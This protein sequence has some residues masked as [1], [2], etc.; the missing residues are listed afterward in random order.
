MLKRI[1]I[2]LLHKSYLSQVVN[3]G[4]FVHGRA[5]CPP[6]AV[7]GSPTPPMASHRNHG[8]APASAGSLGSWL[9]GS[10]GNQDPHGIMRINKFLSSQALVWK[11]SP[12]RSC[13][14]EDRVPT[15]EDYLRNSGLTE[16]ADLRPGSG[17]DTCYLMQ[18]NLLEEAAHL[19]AEEGFFEDPDKPS[20]RELDE[21]KTALEK[22]VIDLL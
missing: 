12:T 14:F 6:A 21:L 9:Q 5:S 1:N 4:A 3:G 11:R 2:G 16:F 19:V 13:L 20:E 15:P 18:E 22:P 10:F 7:V 17:D 8:K